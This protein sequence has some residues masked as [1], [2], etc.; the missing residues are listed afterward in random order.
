MPDESKKSQNPVTDNVGEN[1]RNIVEVASQ[2][3]ITNSANLKNKDG[4]V[5]ANGRYVNFSE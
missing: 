1:L 4:F 3:D 5:D 2:V